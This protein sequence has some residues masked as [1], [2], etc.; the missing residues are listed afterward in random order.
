MQQ[1]HTWDDD[2]RGRGSLSFL[3]QSANRPY[4][5]RAA[6]SQHYIHLRYILILYS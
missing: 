2:D 4:A 3:K 1:N 5:E 6:S